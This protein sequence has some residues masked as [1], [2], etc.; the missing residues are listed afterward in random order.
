M[1]RGGREAAA[2]VVG[3]GTRRAITGPPDHL[4]GPVHLSYSPVG[5]DGA[6]SS[7]VGE[8]EAAPPRVRERRGRRGAVA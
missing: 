5:E 3:E 2:L 7:P 8:G 1:D 4:P 6:S